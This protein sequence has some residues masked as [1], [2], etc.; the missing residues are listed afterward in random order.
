MSKPRASEIGDD[1]WVA[2]R[3]TI[4]PGVR[5]GAGAVITAGSVVMS[6]IPPRVVA[7]GSPARVLRSL[8]GSAL[9][10]DRPPP[11]GAS[12]ATP[13]M[14]SAP[15]V[16]PAFTGT[17][18]S[19]FTVNGL[20]DE[21]ARPDVEPPLAARVA[22]FNQVTQSLLQ[23]P[24]D[25][26]ADFAVVWTL[27]QLAVPLFARVLANELV[28]DE[29]LLS[30]VDAFVAPIRAAAASYRAVFVSTW[31][32]PSSW[33]GLGMRDCR[34]GGTTRALARMN[35]HLMEKLDDLQNVF[36]MPAER[37]F[38]SGLRSPME[39]KAWYLGKIAV[40]A[41]V[42]KEAALDIRAAMSAVHG[43]AR[44]LL[45]LDLDN[46][47]W[48]GVVGDMGWENLQLGGHDAAGEA[49]V[50]FQ[51]AVKALKRRG[52]VLAIVSKN[53]E[54]VALEAI[55]SHPEMV[56]REED[57]VGWKINWRDKAA[58]LAELT[59]ELNL[60]LQSVVFIDDNPIERGRVREALPEVYVPDWPE[61]SLQYLSAFRRLRCFDT[62][63]T[64]KEDLDRTSMYAGERK[65]AALQQQ[66][67][68]LDE[69]LMSLGIQVHV[70]PL[71]AR[72][73]TRA[74]Q[75]LNKTNQM[76]L[77]TRRLTE[78]ELTEWA[79][80]EGRAFYTLTVADS[81]R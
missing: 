22:P 33:R 49:F 43:K 72:N 66:V 60:G 68:S 17:L 8:D 67:G 62:P 78:A 70:E 53:E 56:L 23:P 11:N 69:W 75:L 37:W 59:S 29:D 31:T 12:V 20:V 26:A 76:N 21:L 54:S 47:L 24:L 15:A 45:V 2:G 65:R 46:T 25:G 71:A 64:S 9:P 40:P 7:G 10:A 81:I 14:A 55:R 19:D 44:K 42:L 74:T 50:D 34:V 36:V 3:V 39:P 35:L 38:A 58:N 32:T 27:P 18:I 48:G 52:V 80:S 6:D 61:D 79:A 13:A 5:V 16:A 57:F 1:A 77:T 41:P 51:H 73:L 28:S 30:E 63:S 4:A